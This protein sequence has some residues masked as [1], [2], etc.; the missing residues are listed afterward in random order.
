MIRIK[1]L[2]GGLLAALVI[3]VV[4]HADAQS[5][6]KAPP[7][8]I[9]I[10]DVQAIMREAK[11]AKSARDQMNAIATKEQ[12]KFAAEEKKLRTQDQELLQQRSL[13][14]PEVYAQ[15]QQ[16]LQ[17]EVR[18]LQRK[19][20]DLRLALDQGFKRT[21]EQIQLILIDEIRKLS[22]EF[23]L[24]LVVPRSQIVLAVDDYDITKPALERLDKRLPTIELKLEKRENTDK[25]K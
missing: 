21:M 20:R 25:G 14:T 6:F 19:S 18:R 2:T 3:F 15:R 23:D 7:P 9:A 12:A 24:N 22:K 10:V 11:S 5:T 17:V 4:S 13:L 8:K 16:A 1:S